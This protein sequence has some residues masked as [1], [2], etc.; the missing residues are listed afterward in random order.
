M[1]TALFTNPRLL[2]LVLL[3]ILAGGF[4]ALG[5][6]PRQEDPIVVNRVATILTPFP[7]ASAERVEALVTEK[8]ENELRQISEIE[9]ITSD[10]SNGLSSITVSVHESLSQDEVREALSRVRD[11]LADA[12]SALPAGVPAPRFDDKRSNA[13]SIIVALNWTAASEPN[14]AILRRFGLELQNRLRNV[15]GTQVVRLYGASAEEIL[16]TADPHRLAAAGLS[17]AQVAAALADADVKQSAGRLRSDAS[18]MIIQVQGELDGLDRVRAVPVAQR[19]DGAILRVGDVATV[20]RSVADPPSD[21][22][23]INGRPAVVVT[24]RVVAEMRVDL[25]TERVRTVI[26]RFSAELPQGIAVDIRFEQAVYAESRLESLLLNL[27]SGAAIVVVVLFL[28]LGWRSALICT[29]SLPLTGFATL[30]VLDRIGV[31]INQMSITGLIV[32]LG[33]MVDSAIVMT[34]AVQ[35]RLNRG[36]TPLAALRDAL[37]RLWVPLL[38]STATTILSFMPIVLLP[39]AA[40]E[41]VSAIAVGLIASLTVSYLF[42]ITLVLAVSGRFLRAAVDGRGGGVRLIRWLSRQFSK[43]IALSLRHPRLSML[44]ATI[45]CVLGFVGASTLTEQ[46]FPP[47]DRNQFHIEFR[48]PGQTPIEATAATVRRVSGV[49]DG[50]PE[51]RS[52]DWYVG[53]SAPAFYYNLIMDQ[54]GQAN[55]AQAQVTIDTVAGVEDLVPRLQ[56]AL[57]EAFPEAQTLV[58]E[59]DQGPP[60]DA[61]VELRIYGPD[62]DRLRQIGEQARSLLAQGPTITHTRATLAGGEPTLRLHS[63]EDSARLAGLRLSEVARQLDQQLEGVTGGSVIE[64][65]EELPVRVRLAGAERGDLAAIAA[66]DLMPGGEPRTDG[67]FPGVPL[68]ALGELRLEPAPGSI[69]RRNGERVNIIRGYI[70]AGT[71]PET[72]LAD[73]QQR[74]AANR[75][76]L[77]VGYR[78]EFGGEAEERDQAVDRLMGSIGLIVIGMVVTVVL[79]FNS[80]RLAGG[81]FVVAGQAMGLGLLC[82]TAFGYP[83]G[84]VVIVA[85][86]GLIGLAI[87]ASIIMTAELQGSPAASAGDPEAIRHV[88]VEDCSRHILSTTVTTVGGFLPLMLS[89]GGFWPPFAIAIAG[90]TALST[91]IS[92]YFTP[93]YFSL[94]WR[95]KEADAPAAVAMPAAAAVVPAAG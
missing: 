33:L 28:T 3:M 70:T 18:D 13:F 45:P 11:A 26:D 14:P 52:V 29:A 61:P 80:F 75:L 12:S 84:F 93:A 94:V 74:L 79:T 65:V 86:M 77:P 83:L 39:G 7:G 16:V 92:F 50:F 69:S 9:E 95:R 40:G 48:L 24:A 25:W 62:L 31:P 10:S 90:G 67:R 57:D 56:H 59:L 78:T 27:L 64:A 76:D 53:T 81:I 4:S 20:Q 54:D 60:F 89:D 17:M 87:N 34:D 19:S 38:S 44:A 85:L 73:F 71:L 47:A 35:M 82:L 58:R 32:A 51:I 72:A 68:A 66:T 21:L 30:A 8:I 23:L 46:F 88:V 2:A 42:A 15:G 36:M 6:L 22:V 1:S 41:F 49:L 55:Y 43:S 91:I 63:D 37:A 5:T